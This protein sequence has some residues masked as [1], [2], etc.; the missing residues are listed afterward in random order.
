M[1]SE[2]CPHCGMPLEDLSELLVA[3]KNGVKFFIA[4][5]SQD[6]ECI[7]ELEEAIQKVES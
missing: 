3:A 2:E 6:L 5:G 4:N 1:N 7:R